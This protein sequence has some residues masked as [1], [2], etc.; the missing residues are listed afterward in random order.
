MHVMFSVSLF[1]GVLLPGSTLSQTG[2]GAPVRVLS[3]DPYRSVDWDTVQQYKGNLH[4][5]TTQSDGSLP[6]QQV[7]DEYHQRGYQVLALTD[8]DKVT[9]PWTELDSF[10]PAYENRNPAALGMLAISGNE[11]SR[12]HHVQS[13]FSDFTSVSTDLEVELEAQGQSAPTALALLNHPAWHWSR[14]A[15]PKGFK[16]PMTTVFR[17]ITGGD[18]TVEAWFRCADK[19]RNI[20]MGNY[21]IGTAGSLNL[22]LHTDNRVRLYLQ[23]ESGAVT[24]RNLSAGSINTRDGQWHHVAGLRRNGKLCL[25]LDGQQLGAEANDMSGAYALQGDDYWIGRD[26]RVGATEFK[27]DLDE[28]RLWS[29]ALTADEVVSLAA[30][31]VPGG[32]GVLAAGVLAAYTFDRPAQAADTAGHINGPFHG[33]RVEPGYRVALTPT[34]QQVTQ[35]D[36][37]VEAWFRTTD[38]ERN[39]LLG[40]YASSSVSA[41]N[42]ELHTDNR[43]RL[44]IQPPVGQGSTLSL[45]ATPGS[46]TRDGQW[47]HLAGV[48][49]AGIAYLYLDGQ[50]AG[51]MN[52]TSGNFN[53]QGAYTYIGRDSRLG[54]TV[55]KGDLAPLRLWN[56][57]L[58]PEEV[59][60]LAGG[61]RGESGGVSHVDLLACYELAEA[62]RAA[63]TAGHADGPFDGE[64]AAFS[65]LLR[66]YDVAAPLKTMGTSSSGISLNW[67]PPYPTRV[68]LEVVDYYAGVFQRH[69]HLF[70][71]EVL[72]GTMAAREYPLDRELWDALLARLMPGR[73]VW[74]MANDDMH[75]L[76]QLGRDWSVFP[77]AELSE[78]AVRQALESGAYYFSTTRVHLESGGEGTQPPRLDRVVHDV[79]AG[80]ITL[81][82]STNSVPLPERAYTWISMGKIMHVGSSFDYRAA[83]VTG[84][85]VRAE[86]SGLAGT[87]YTNPFGFST[88]DAVADTDA[89]GLPD[90][91]ELAYFG[92]PTAVAAEAVSPAGM[93]LWEH[94]VAGSDPRD[95]DARFKVIHVGTHAEV[96]T[97]IRLSW[98]SAAGRLYAVEH[99]GD[100]T[101]VFAPL[102]GAE[103]IEAQPPCN[104]YL[105]D[106]SAPQGFYR[107]KVRLAD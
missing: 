105:V 25:Y 42:L 36:F 75:S 11:L 6:P 73:P 8:H 100:L 88:L 15:T 106:A 56:R 24:D 2:M 74:G 94:Y 107:I 29:R 39:V 34:L 64:S 71:M 65:S 32:G 46:N 90:W 76:K 66:V 20:L 68:P 84:S 18:F 78:A 62:T 7:I 41:L 37:T 96:A 103:A 48:R 52:D 82:A 98:P 53:L 28:V 21:D 35:G 91:W 19:E 77:T 43:V 49:R 4:T 93:T 83:G 13:L 50:E 27:G 17:Q 72:N 101:E 92:H 59:A 16:I 45:F 86:I 80:R 57:G 40:N 87:T 12:H 1:V 79:A 67:S 102:A 33:E 31:E 51:R 38:T 55:F 60:V 81:S 5:H 69:T 14:T 104:E 99:A 58:S 70:G 95:P 22:E 23:S 9:Y 54:A 3:L 10:N 89:D 97:K 47:R 85:Y 26:A 63:D 61:G 30:G 44:Y